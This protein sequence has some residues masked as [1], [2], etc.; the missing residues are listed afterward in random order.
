M[1]AFLSFYGIF[2]HL[3]DTFTAAFEVLLII[4]LV[5]SFVKCIVL[6]NIVSSLPQ[7]DQAMAL[8]MICNGR[9]RFDSNDRNAL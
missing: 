7:A 6:H 8:V 5:R 1:S 3:P 2:L 4:L 9:S